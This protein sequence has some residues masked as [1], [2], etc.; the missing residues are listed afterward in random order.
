MSEPLY[1]YGPELHD[2]MESAWEYDK[3]EFFNK[4]MAIEAANIE[5][6]T[7]TQDEVRQ[8][9]EVISEIQSEAQIRH[10]RMNADSANLE[11]PSTYSIPF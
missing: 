3:T 2:R 8:L 4:F 10:D 9:Q 6:L 7:L 5:S 11:G 1:G